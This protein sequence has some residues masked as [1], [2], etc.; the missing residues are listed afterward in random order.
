M[1]RFKERERDRDKSNEKESAREIVG[2]S[3]KNYLESI[4]KMKYNNQI[5]QKSIES[6]V[7]LKKKRILTTLLTQA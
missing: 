1:Y 5:L 4:P 7:C 6:R 3:E 2:E